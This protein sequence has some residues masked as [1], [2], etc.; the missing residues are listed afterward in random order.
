MTEQF[1]LQFDNSPDPDDAAFVRAG[2]D[3]FNHARAAPVNYQPLAIFARDADAAL[4]GGLLGATYWSWLYVDILWLDEAVRGRRL[5]SQLIE[6]AER[7]ARARGCIGAHLD[8]TDFQALP[9]YQRH[10]YIVYGEI[11]DMPPGHQRY[12]LSKRLDQ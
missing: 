4:V 6:Q 5:G 10:G 12:F 11:A 9:F 3:A 2:L 1:T 7:E 8:T